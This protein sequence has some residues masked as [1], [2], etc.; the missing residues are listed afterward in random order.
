MK[1]LKL[2]QNVMSF[3]GLQLIRDSRR[4]YISI[5]SIRNVAGIE[6]SELKAAMSKIRMREH[7]IFVTW[8]TR[9][10]HTTCIHLKDLPLLAAELNGKIPDKLVKEI[11]KDYKELL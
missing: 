2:K 1:K 3:R 7:R 11:T 4:P 9:K 5:G 6:G 10:F 8:A